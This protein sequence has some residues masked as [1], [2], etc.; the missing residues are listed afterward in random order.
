MTSTKFAPGEFLY[1][2]QNGKII[3]FQVFGILVLGIEKPEIYYII[4]SSNSIVIGNTQIIQESLKEP[5]YI[6]Q[7]KTF[8]SPE[9]LTKHLLN[10]YSKFNKDDNDSKSEG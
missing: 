6:H 4:N 5:D 8:K 10:Q 2:L 3:K 1:T 7:S 9:A